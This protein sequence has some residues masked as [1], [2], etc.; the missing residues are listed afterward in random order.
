MACGLKASELA[1]ASE[2]NSDDEGEE[3]SEDE[4]DD[5]GERDEDDGLSRKQRMVFKED[6]AD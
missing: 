4:E 6:E 5:E 1:N 3:N 2:L